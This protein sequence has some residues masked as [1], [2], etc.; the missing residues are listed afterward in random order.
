MCAA[1]LNVSHETEEK[2]RD[3]VALLAKWQKSVNLVSPA[4]I[5]DAWNRHILDSAQMVEL[6]PGPVKNVVDFGSGAGFPALVVAIMRPDLHI[7]LVES[8][9]K[10]CSFLAHVSRETKTNIAIHTMRIEEFVPESP[11]DLVMAR[12]L[13][14]LSQ[15]LKYTLPHAVRNP[16]L[17]MLFPKGAKFAEEIAQAREIY[18]FTCE[19]FVSKTAADARILRLSGLCIK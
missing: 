17:V 3:Y 8:D 9:Q 10:K 13:A 7:Q 1:P 5:D 15:L 14:P 6:I 18:D 12:A 2:L 11:P 4:T 16:D 19:Q